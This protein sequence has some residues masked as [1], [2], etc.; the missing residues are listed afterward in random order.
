MKN[1]LV[2]LFRYHVKSCTLQFMA[3]LFILALILI[4]ILDPSYAEIPDMGM[5]MFMDFHECSER[6]CGWGNWHLHILI[7]LF[8]FIKT[9]NQNP[10]SSIRHGKVPIQGI[11]PGLQ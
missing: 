10:I 5:F 1:I 6:L 7:I 2:N 9:K 3:H 4:R 11:I 8:L